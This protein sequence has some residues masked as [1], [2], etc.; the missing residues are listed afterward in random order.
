MD[1]RSSVTKTI[2]IILTATSLT[3]AT[4]LNAGTSE[5]FSSDHNSILDAD[6]NGTF[7]SLNLRLNSISA[8]YFPGI[9][10]EKGILIFN[11]AQL[12]QRQLSS[13]VLNARVVGYTSS[14]QTVSVTALAGDLTIDLKDATDPAIPVGAYNPTE[15]GLN[16]IQIPLDA[17]SI[18]TILDTGNHLTL[19]IESETRGTNTQLGAAGSWP[20]SLTVEYEEFTGDYTQIHSISDGRILD[21]D[22]NGVFDTIDPAPSS[23]SVRTFSFLKEVS[24]SHFDIDATN[25]MAA[26]LALLQIDIV[27][28]ANGTSHVDIYGFN[29]N[30]STELEDATTLGLLL[31]SYNPAAE[32]LGNHTVVLNTDNLNQLIWHGGALTLRFSRRPP[33]LSST[34]I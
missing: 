7:D 10:I 30:M 23:L 13:V 19:R 18:Q 11:L 32:G 12:Q 14:T 3:S 28:I 15:A 27:G 8:R 9:V 4:A 2:L 6:G 33:I 22:G 25:G 34:F 17:A 5:L 1:I 24:V 20:A 26:E 31:G 21:D 16:W 29:N